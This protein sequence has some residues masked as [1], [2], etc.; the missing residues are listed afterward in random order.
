M[1]AGGR[2]GI[3]ARRAGSRG[4]VPVRQA[5]IA[6]QRYA[7]AA[8]DTTFR[9][10]NNLQHNRLVNSVL[11]SL[12]KNHFMEKRSMEPARVCFG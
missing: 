5:V 11:G 8:P 3:G 4:S 9:E 12:E 1:P 6:G 10:V 2:A 7:F